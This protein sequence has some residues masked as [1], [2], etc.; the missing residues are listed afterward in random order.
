MCV[1]Q[2]VLNEVKNTIKQYNMFSKNDTVIVGVS[3]GADSV[4]LL[5]VLNTI[6]EDYKLN[7]IVAHVNHKIRKGTAERDA[8]FVENLCEKMGLE[9][10][11]KEISIPKV[12]EVFS[13]SEEEAGRKVRYDFFSELAG[14][15][16]KIATAHNANDNVETVLMRFMRGTGVKGLSGIPFVRNNIVRP[17]LNI[18][19]EE[20]EQYIKENNL[21]H[22]T[23]ETNF[24]N[25]YTRN[26]IRLDLIP[27]IK[28]NFNPN[29]INTVNDN[30]LTYKEDADYFDKEVEKLFKSSVKKK[31][32]PFICLLESL[33]NNHPAHSKRLILRTLTGF[34]GTNQSNISADMI[35]KIYKGINSK[36][37]TIFVANKNCQVRVG[38]DYL[39]FER[40][41][42]ELNENVYTYEFGKLEEEHVTYPEVNLNLSFYNV[43]D[44]NIT[45]TP[46][47]FF[48]PFSEYEGKT[49]QIRTRRE[50]DVFRVEDGVHK[51]LNK[52]FVDKK[53]DLSM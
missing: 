49:L 33:K 15:N 47:E 35:N 32:G 19:R 12:A 9:F 31:N 26:K 42:K 23:D 40:R 36:V 5:H 29:L 18:S 2:K 41:E 24:E 34:L 51:K 25:I 13:I 45:N 22:I 17:I 11:L 6:K 50:G 14:F 53:L 39:Y 21:T 38:Y 27:F 52:F 46:N 48:L 30:I 4:M 28:E 3:G 20:I 37:G 8:D 1:T 44:L 10:H 43:W 16:G 7:L